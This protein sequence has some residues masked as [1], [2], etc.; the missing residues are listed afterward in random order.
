MTTNPIYTWPRR[1]TTS[2]GGS[3]DTAANRKARKYSTR[4]TLGRILWSLVSPLF[5]LSPR[6]C[7]GW[8]RF[9]LRIFGARLGREVHVYA[10]AIIYLPWNL[11]VGNWSSIGEHARIYNLGKISIGSHVT[12]SHGAH[13]CAGTHDY[14]NPTMPLRKE[15]IRVDD[16]AW[17][18]TEAFVG[19]GARVGE[20]AVVG[21]RAVALEDVELW[22]V[23]AGN[24]ARFLKKR[25]LK[26]T[27]EEK[28]TLSLLA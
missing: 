18:C 20:G 26:I 25:E 19:P 10:S 3:L 14:T 24:P 1:I 6:I 17:I 22:A 9:L 13:L 8:R 12:V 16:Q 5:R 7:F 21:A 11:E 27:E 15:P 4:E 23:V 2:A 28:Q